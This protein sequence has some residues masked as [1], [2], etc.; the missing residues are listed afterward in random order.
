MIRKFF[1]NKAKRLLHKD[2]FL[3]LSME[4]CIGNIQLPCR[5]I[6]M[7]GNGQNSSNGTRL[8]NKTKGVCVINTIKLLKSLGHKTSFK[9]VKSAIGLLFHFVNPLIGDDVLGRWSKAKGSGMIGLKSNKFILHSLLP[10]R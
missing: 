3:Q 6:K 5:P 7:N 4:K 2:F 10:V 9:S 8:N 1:V